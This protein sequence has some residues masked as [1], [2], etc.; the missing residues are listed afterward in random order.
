M[1]VGPLGS[2]SLPSGYLCYN[3]LVSGWSDPSLFPALVSFVGILGI[4][5]KRAWGPA[6]AVVASVCWTI[7]GIGTKQLG[8]VLIES[9]AGALYLAT[10]IEWLMTEK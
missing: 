9:L 1:V 7:Y 3:P 8:I 5:K 4:R 10:T 6:V 2:G